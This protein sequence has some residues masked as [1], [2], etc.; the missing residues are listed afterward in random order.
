MKILNVTGCVG[1]R[2]TTTCSDWDV[3]TNVKNN[4]K[5]FC[6]SPCSEDHHIII[7]AAHGETK[8]ENGITLFNKGEDLFVTFTNLQK[9]DSKTYFCGLERVGP[10]KYIKVNLNVKDVTTSSTMSSNSSDIITNMS[11]PYT[12][13]N[14]T[15]PAASATQG[16]GRSL[17]YLV[18]GVI[19]ILTILMVS[20]KLMSKM[21]KQQTKVTSRADTPQEDAQE[22]VEYDKIRPEDQTAQEFLCAIYSQH[23]DTE[24]AA[25]SDYSYLNDPFRFED[26]SRGACTES[27]VTYDLV[28]SVA[29][30]PEEQIQPIGQCE[31]NPSESNE[32]DSLYSQ[33][34]LPLAT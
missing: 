21:M 17:P 33:A 12:T 18:I 28:Y 14:T 26:N 3:W 4:V 10:D 22:D 27:R 25:E 15:T 6:V 7:K 34:Q 5:Y 2:V 30:L 8:H 1:E 31:P 20:L 19:A 9:S 11:T 32:N 16:F 29:Q 13:L 24:L 23:Q